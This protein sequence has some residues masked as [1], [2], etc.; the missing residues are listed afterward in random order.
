MRQTGDGKASPSDA[1]RTLELVSPRQRAERPAQ[2]EEIYQRVREEGRRRLSRPLLELAAT[3]LVGGFDVSF[4][5]VAFALTAG[6][7]ETRFGSSVAHALGALAFGIGFVF[8][9]VGKSELFTENFL[10]PIAGLERNQRSVL[11]L[12]ELWAAA[13]FLNLVGGAGIALIL[14]SKGVLGEDA[15]AQL[16]RLAERLAGYGVL[17]AFLSAVVAGALMTLMTWFVEGAAESMGVRI[18]M[19][20]I[21]GAL[22][23]LG[24]FNHAVVSTIELV[25]G[26]R[27]GANVSMSDLLRNL[28]LALGGNLVGGLLLVTFARSAQAFAANG[29]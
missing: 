10:V 11:K 21:V 2:P 28:S 27:Y 18:L 4:G 19:S 13:L 3:A 15:P 29:S 1:E 16:T 23:L 6:A 5:V 22:I 26:L 25:F 8:V 9:V 14:T 7:V 12:G 17:T 20:W 24:T